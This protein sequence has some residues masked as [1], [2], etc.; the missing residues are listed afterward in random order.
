MGAESTCNGVNKLDANNTI[1][2]VGEWYI[3]KELDLIYFSVFASDPV[4]SDTSTDVDDDPW[5]AIDAMTPLHV[6]VRSS[7]TV[8]QGV[9]DA[10]E[11]FFEVPAGRKDQKLILFRR[12]E[13]K[14]TTCEDSESETEPF[15]SII[16]SQ[17]YSE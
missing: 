2:D 9:S 3:N 5:S 7:L 16:T 13:F 10:Q 4:P 12:V 6:P 1:N 15:S 8:Y 14:P 11:T 17:M